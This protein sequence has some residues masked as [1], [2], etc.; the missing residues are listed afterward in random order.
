MMS[1]RVQ[2][3]QANNAFLISEDFIH[4][5]R[6]RER[7]RRLFGNNGFV[8]FTENWGLSIERRHTKNSC[9]AQ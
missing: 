5:P 3:S 4:Q 8:D 1:Q 2:A 6:D 7:E 9:H